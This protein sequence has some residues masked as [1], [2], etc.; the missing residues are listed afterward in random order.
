MSHPI[1]EH[2]MFRPVRA[3]VVVCVLVALVMGGLHAY[4]VT[5][6]CGV[7]VGDPED[8]VAGVLTAIQREDRRGLCQR[9]MPDYAIPAE[10]MQV[11]RQRIE[12]AGGAGD[13][14]V[15]DLKEL[16]LGA[17]HVLSVSSEDGEVV[18][19]FQTLVGERGS[20]VV[21]VSTSPGQW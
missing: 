20:I 1:T 2:R 16:Q 12:E 15:K 3:I 21:A 5:R 10:Q 13:L 11:L 18:A 9:L 14:R 17:Q 6:P 19:Q 8:A 7:G 4:R